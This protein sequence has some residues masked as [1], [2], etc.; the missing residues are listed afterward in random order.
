MGRRTPAIVT[1]LLL[2]SGC[3]HREDGE[4]DEYDRAAV[5]PAAD[6]V[7]VRDVIVSYEGAG[8]EDGATIAS[9]LPPSSRDHPPPDPV[10]FRIGAG[11]GA[12]GHLD[13]TT[14]RDQGLQRGYL[15]MR[16]T[17]R[18]SGHI[19]HAAVEA[20]APPPPEALECIGEQLE[21]AMVPVFDGGDV[22]LSR[23]YFVN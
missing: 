2:A 22:T 15:H 18:H 12:L 13:L 20:P 4:I 11:H 9:P 17:F 8:E 10:P 5:D 7:V 21:V 3:V 6:P 16:V 14:C 19:V 1:V 23:S